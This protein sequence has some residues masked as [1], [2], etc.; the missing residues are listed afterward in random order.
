MASGT[1]A[2][3]TVDWRSPRV[4]GRQEVMVAGRVRIKSSAVIDAENLDLRTIKSAVLTPY[5]VQPVRSGGPPILYGSVTV[6]GSL[7]NS[8]RVRSFR[9]SIV[10]HTGTQHVGTAAG[11]TMQVGFLI[12]GA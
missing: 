4:R 7:M 12:V 10:P 5:D 3:P 2:A 1:I 11:G 6:T 9:G 8:V